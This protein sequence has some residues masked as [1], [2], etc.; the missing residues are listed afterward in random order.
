MKKQS[1]FC[2][3]LV[4]S[5]L[6]SLLLTNFACA[7][8]FEV[9]AKA[10]LLI[11][12]D[13]GEILYAKDIHKEVYPASLTKIMV[14]ILVMEDL[15]SGKIAMG[16]SITA[17]AKAVDHNGSSVG[18][19][20]G[21][22]IGVKDLFY[23]M[24]VA[25]ANEA[26]NMFAEALDGSEEAFVARM[27]EKAKALGCKNTHFVNT[28]GL[29]DDAHYSSAWDI[30]LMTCEALKH[31]LF[32]EVC[33]TAV[34]EVPAT[35]LSEG[36]RIHTTN[37]LLSNWRWIGYMY[38]GAQ[39]IKTG[40]TDEAGQCL[41]S[42][43]VRG[44]RTLLS[45]VIGADK[46]IQP[47]GKTLVKSFSET[48]RMFDWGFDNFS[49]RQIL[50]AEDA[51]AEVPVDLSSETNYVIAHPES[52]LFCTLPKD[53][54]E[55]QI[56]R[57]VTLDAERAKAP[58]SAG[59]PLGSISVSYRGNLCGT[60]P[61]VALNDVSASRILVIKD[62]LSRFFHSGFVKLLLVILLIVLVLIVVKIFKSPKGRRGSRS[63][64]SGYRGRRRR[65]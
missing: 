50:S 19:K 9:D 35:N 8:S 41:V 46:V 57:T 56:E 23:C 7:D 53:M 15:E 49:R 2:F 31:D 13:T 33:N 14:A 39:G 10:A 51:I 29:H 43:A 32:M 55:T 63:F 59:D 44:S 6:A 42:S 38:K 48:I 52:D 47:N 65:Q 25:S 3:F 62:A 60:V 26:C 5:L 21:E 11:E 36:R 37:S 17:S 45:V 54:D 64:Y 1:F 34:Y 4:F 27:N 28:N 24:L 20:A 30:Y 18:I 58:I 16:D 12:Q 61:L 22:T 40:S